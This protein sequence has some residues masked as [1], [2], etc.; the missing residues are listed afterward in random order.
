MDSNNYFVTGGTGFVGRFLIE[1]L[2]ARGGRIYVLTRAASIAKIDKLRNL[3]NA[4]SE[5]LVAVV[6]DL[7]DARLGLSDADIDK[8]RGSIAHF[9]HV[10]AI[11]DLTASEEEQ[12][13]AN[14]NGT[15]NAIDCAQALQA[16]CFQHVSSTAVSGMYSGTFREDMFEEAENLNN[17]YFRTKHASEAIV[18]KECQVPWRI[19]RPSGILGHSASGEID[20]IDGPYYSFPMIKKLRGLP[21]WLRLPGVNAGSLNLVPVDYV[22]DAM[23]HIAHQP[24]LDGGCFQL[25]NTRQY[26]ATEMTN[27][28]AKVAGAT[29]LSERIQLNPDKPP[30]RE[31]LTIKLL[32]RLGSRLVENAGLPI[33]AIKMMQWDTQYDSTETQRALADSAITLPDLEDYANVLWDFWEQHLDPERSAV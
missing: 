23:D 30:L 11:Y 3:L 9:F 15:R 32:Q 16:G 28:F 6:G 17:A 25:T 24:D 14:V 10:A 13:L 31:L 4:S 5:Q 7:S 8:L 20:K 33:E 26:S 1:R 19:Y 12:Q 18:R 21:S 27:I 22:V 29:P 2:L